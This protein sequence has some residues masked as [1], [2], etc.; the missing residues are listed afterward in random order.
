MIVHKKF[1]DIIVAFVASEENEMYILSL[2]NLMMN[3]MDKL[4]GGIH[5]KNFIYNF[6][7]V[8]YTIDNFIL[9]GKVINLDPMDISISPHYLKPFTKESDQ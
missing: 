8:S 6:K 2:I 7:D 4:L 3:A 5:Q 1:D 9:N